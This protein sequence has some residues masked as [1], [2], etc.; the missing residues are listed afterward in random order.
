MDENGQIL[1]AISKRVTSIKYSADIT[2]PKTTRRDRDLIVMLIIGWY[3]M[4]LM[5]EEAAAAAAASAQ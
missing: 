4:V 1:C 2:I 3:S 5:S